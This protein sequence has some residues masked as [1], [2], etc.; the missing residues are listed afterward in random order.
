MEKERRGYEAVA[1]RWQFSAAFKKKWGE[2]SPDN[3]PPGFQTVSGDKI[4]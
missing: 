1:E 4:S 2:L 3:S